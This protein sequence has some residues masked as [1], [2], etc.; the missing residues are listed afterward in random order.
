MRLLPCTFH[1]PNTATAR[2]TTTR[3]YHMLTPNARGTTATAV[4]AKTTATW[5]FVRPATKPALEIGAK[6]EL[7]TL[8][9]ISFY[10]FARKN[11]R[12]QSGQTA[13]IIQIN[14]FPDGNH[15]V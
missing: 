1:A 7:R 11:G 8:I 10:R 5:A 13:G 12:P 14:V 3:H 15:V 9:T 4:A 2:Q 6:L